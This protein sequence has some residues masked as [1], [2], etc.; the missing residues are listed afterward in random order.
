MRLHTYMYM[1]VVQDKHMYVKDTQ[2]SSQ[3]FLRLS[4]HKS[5]YVHVYIYTMLKRLVK[6]G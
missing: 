5:M 2:R 1:H 3:N 4:E 6:D